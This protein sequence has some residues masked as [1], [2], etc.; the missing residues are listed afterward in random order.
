MVC[1]QSIP[2]REE[3]AALQSDTELEPNQKSLAPTENLFKPASLTNLK[4]STIVGSTAR[5]P[6]A[7]EYNPECLSSGPE[8]KGRWRSALLLPREG[9]I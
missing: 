1:D 3:Q 8:L 4:A 6:A 9:S 7:G 5:M 2:S